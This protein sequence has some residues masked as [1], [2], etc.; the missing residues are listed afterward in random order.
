MF[1]I[2][3]MKITMFQLAGFY[4]MAILSSMPAPSKGPW[5]YCLPWPEPAQMEYSQNWKFRV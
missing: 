1:Y 4:C 2:K 5:Q 3:F